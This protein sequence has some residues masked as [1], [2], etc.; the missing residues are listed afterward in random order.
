MVNAIRIPYS[1]TV[2]GERNFAGGWESSILIVWEGASFDS[3]SNPMGIESGAI[4]KLQPMHRFPPEEASLCAADSKRNGQQVLGQ[5]WCHQQR[6]RGTE[7]N[8]I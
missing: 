1:A 8:D 5:D 4:L 7:G 6:D 2:L 3:M